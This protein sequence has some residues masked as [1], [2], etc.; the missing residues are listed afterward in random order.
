MYHGDYDV[1]HCHMTLMNI[2][3]LIAAKKCNIKIRISHSHNSDVQDKN[4]LIK[5]E[6]KI[7]SF[8]TKSGVK[9]RYFNT[10][11]FTIIYNY[12]NLF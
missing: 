4:I 10:E 5:K 8:F 9:A 11:R 1:V 7:D 3:P 12:K 2:F 6:S